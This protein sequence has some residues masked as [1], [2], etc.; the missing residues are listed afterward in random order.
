MDEDGHCA[1]KNNDNT[2]E[3][4]NAI[5]K[6][7]DSTA[8]SK[9]MDKNH[10][11]PTTEMSSNGDSDSNKSTMKSTI[12]SSP[13]EYFMTTD[14]IEQGET[15]TS[16]QAEKTGQNQ[17]SSSLIKKNDS[18][19]AT[20]QGGKTNST[21]TFQQRKEEAK[22]R[23]RKKKKT[24]SSVVATTFHDLYHLS[25]EIL[26]QGAYASVRTCRNIWTDQEFAVK[27]IDKVPGHARSRVFKEIETFHHCRGH[28]NIIQLIEYFEEADRFYL[29]FEKI[30]GGQLLD[31][32][33]NRVRFTEKEASYVIRDLASALQFLHKKGIAHRD[34][35]PENVLCEYEDQLCPVK[36]CDFDLGSGIKFNSQ[37]TSPISTP[38]LLTPVGSAEFMAP[39]VVEA[40]MDDSE[41]DLAYDKKCDLWSLGIIMYILLC[42]YPPFSGNCG[43][44]CGWNQGEP[45]NACQE[46]LFH[47]IQDGHFDFPE[48]EWR[49]ISLEAKDLISKLLVKDPRKRLSAEQVLEH[50]WVKYGGPSRVLVTPQNIKRNNSARELSAFAESAMAVNRVVLQHMS[51]N[52]QEHELEE[53]NP[54]ENKEND[55]PPI[56]LPENNNNTKMAEKRKAPPP[57]GL[58]PPSESKLLQRRTKQSQSLNFSC[59]VKSGLTKN[60]NSFVNVADLV[61]NIVESPGC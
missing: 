51:I 40:F 11:I 50:P 47:S 39:E 36:L 42:G 3:T 15:T 46:L 8:T 28:K 55:E 35:K 21:E 54:E 18:N 5:T 58:S 13:N 44:Q 26:G 29:V 52:L 56:T 61:S 27:I 41:R 30:H 45:C 9:T 10:P 60:S 57:F 1:A 19:E 14:E 43:S 37:L 31:H 25:N 53:E 17:S 4:I 34:L 2:I 20:T 6:F 33:Q 49:E 7:N 48:T 59:R 23:R 22:S 32:I 38:A 12:E 24:D 16:D